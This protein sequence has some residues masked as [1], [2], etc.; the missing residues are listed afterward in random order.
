MGNRHPGKAVQVDPCNTKLTPPG[1]KRLKLKCDV[2]HST[3]AFTFNL[4]RY[5]LGRKL[6]YSVTGTLMVRRCRLTLSNPS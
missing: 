1:T 3:S 2:L 4:R 5:I 6:A